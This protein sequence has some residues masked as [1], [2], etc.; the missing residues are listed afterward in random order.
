MLFSVHLPAVPVGAVGGGTGLQTQSEC[1]SVLGIEPDPER[2]GSAARRLAEVAGAT[3]LAGEIS[4]MSALASGD[5][6]SA[7]ERLA[8]GGSA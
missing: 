7:H 6:A 1:L 3:V 4:L 8:R 2:P 5:L